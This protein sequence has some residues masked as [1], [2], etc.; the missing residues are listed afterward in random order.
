MLALVV[1]VVVV[2]GIV[3]TVEAVVVVISVT[4]VS[5]LYSLLTS[6][7]KDALGSVSET[8]Y[9]FGRLWTSLYTM[10]I[11]RVVRKIQIVTLFPTNKPIR[12]H[13]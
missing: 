8:I 2:L 13:L 5:Y 12:T 6:P 4:I 1:V 7:N 11:C 9:Q 10:F 3:I